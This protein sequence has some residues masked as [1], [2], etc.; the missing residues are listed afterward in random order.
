MDILKWYEPGDI[1]NAEG[2][3]LIYLMLPA[4]TSGFKCQTHHGTKESKVRITLILT[5]NMNRSDKLPIFCI[6]K[7]KYPRAFKHL[8]SLPVPHSANKK[9]WMTSKLFDQWLRKLNLQM[10]RNGRKILWSLTTAQRI[11]LTSMRTW[12]LYFCH[13]ESLVTPSRWMPERLGILSS[14]T[15]ASSPRDAWMQPKLRPL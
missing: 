1:Y 6:G 12:N 7:S 2:T 10:W 9:A 4:N 11:R 5:A 13:R 14:S 15:V 3:G 8:R